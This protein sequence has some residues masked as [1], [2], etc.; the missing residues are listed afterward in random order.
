M[1]AIKNHWS[2]SWMCQ[3]FE[4]GLR[5]TFTSWKLAF[6]TCATL[7]AI[8][9]AQDQATSTLVGV[10]ATISA[11]NRTSAPTAVSEIEF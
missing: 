11:R 10:R 8:E 3:N 5:I 4:I 9:F 1:F 7:L 6:V 2:C